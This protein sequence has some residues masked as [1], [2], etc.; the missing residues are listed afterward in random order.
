VIFTPKKEIG[1]MTLKLYAVCPNIYDVFNTGWHVEAE[2][3]SDL[4]DSVYLIEC[5][6]CGEIHPYPRKEIIAVK[7]PDKITP[8]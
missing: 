4:G 2:K 1:T 8:C 7:V 6:C 5:N 3:L